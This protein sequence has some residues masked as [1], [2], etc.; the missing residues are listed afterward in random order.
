[1][2]S[3]WQ[4]CPPLLA[5]WRVLYFWDQ[6][7]YIFSKTPNAFAHQWKF[8][9]NFHLSWLFLLFLFYL[10]VPLLAICRWFSWISHWNGTNMMM[11]MMMMM[12]ILQWYSHYNYNCNHLSSSFWE[13]ETIFY[14][15]NE[16]DKMNQWSQHFFLVV[17]HRKGAPP[18]NGLRFPNGVVYVGQW[19]A[20]VC[21]F[22]MFFMGLNQHW[23][24][25]GIVW[26]YF[27][28]F[29]CIFWSIHGVGVRFSMMLNEF[30]KVFSGISWGWICNSAIRFKWYIYGTNIRRG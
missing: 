29:D 15:S 16:H 25:D 28:I 27:G 11:M 26:W 5:L 13:D 10:R 12:M 2:L 24:F 14:Q 3:K 23:Y 18:L 1:M 9:P 30:Y 4:K 17:L 20:Q 6:N 7:I 22:G 21:I 19:E 8:F